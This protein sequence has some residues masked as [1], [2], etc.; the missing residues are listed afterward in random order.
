MRSLRAPQLALLLHRRQPPSRI[1]PD[2]CSPVVQDGILG[3]TT[4]CHRMLWLDPV[5]VIPVRPTAADH[6]VRPA[7]TEPRHRARII[8]RSLRDELGAE[9]RPIGEPIR[10][11]PVLATASSLR[12]SEPRTRSSGSGAGTSPAHR[13]TDAT[14]GAGPGPTAPVATQ[15][16]SGRR[17]PRGRT[18]PALALSYRSSTLP[19]LS[20]PSSAATASARRAGP[21]PHRPAPDS[22]GSGPSG[23]RA[24]S[25]RFRPRNC[26]SRRRPA[27][28]R[29]SRGGFR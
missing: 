14:F 11:P 25:D 22:S 9:P 16:R 2:R 28:G 19:P 24:P 10:L 18:R 6:L 12:S 5:D 3:D 13:W 21:V 4:T 7:G 17:E 20:S 23:W 26:A 27:R 29:R 1:H 15:E 8:E